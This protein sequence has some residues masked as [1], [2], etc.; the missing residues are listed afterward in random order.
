MFLDLAKA[1]DTVDHTILYS[2]LTYYGFQG[3][4]YDLLCYYF[5]DQRQRVLFNVTGV[6]L[7]LECHSY[8]GRSFAF[9]LVVVKH[10]ILDLYADDAELLCITLI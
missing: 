9:C 5:M 2:K 3:T 8:V 10:C 7:Q 1:F 4:S 6:L